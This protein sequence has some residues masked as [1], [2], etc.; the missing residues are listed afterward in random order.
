MAD[1]EFTLPRI[2]LPE[3][4]AFKVGDIRKQ[5]ESIEKW[6]DA[7]KKTME[8]KSDLDLIH[9]PGLPNNDPH[10]GGADCSDK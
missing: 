5:I 3:S 9:L 8:G 6:A 2:K 7:V 1:H 10:I 4:R